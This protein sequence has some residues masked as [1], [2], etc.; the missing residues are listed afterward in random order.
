MVLV[1]LAF[2]KRSSP[3]M[4][5]ALL[6][7]AVGLA[8]FWGALDTIIIAHRFRELV[9]VLFVLYIAHDLQSVNNI[10]YCFLVFVFINMALFAYLFFVLGGGLFHIDYIGG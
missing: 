2:W 7:Q 3:L 1:G 9:F 8:I 10:K 6:A 4:H 5:R